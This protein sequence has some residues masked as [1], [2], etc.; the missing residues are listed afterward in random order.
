M[1]TQNGE[2]VSLRVLYSENLG[3]N[4]ADLGLPEYVLNSVNT[5]LNLSEGLILLTGG[6]GSGKTTTM[7]TSINQIMDKSGG[8][9]NVITLENPVEYI[10][11]GAVQSQIN[12]LRGYTYPK[13]LKTSLRQNPDVILIGEINDKE[14]AQTAVRAS[15]SGHLVFSTLH[16]ND[17]L[18]VGQSMEYYG[19]NNLELSWALQLIINQK[20]ANKLCPKC[21]KKVMIS[22]VKKLNWINRLGISEELLNVYEKSE[23]G[24]EECKGYGYKGRVLICS[25]LDANETYTKLAM[26]N[27]TLVELEKALINDDS[28]KY[29]TLNQDV[30]RH[31][32]AG[33][34]DLITAKGLLR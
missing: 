34:I 18:S 15:T 32:K 8:T 33:N 1:P 7:Y 10:I 13:A 4:V 22:D 29:Y 19:V 6:T 24:C 11:A 21:R 25:M 23:H 26:Q 20:L 3:R 31:L 9:K 27:M 16:T 17:V 5:V 12:E 28:A 14:T 30:F 2:N